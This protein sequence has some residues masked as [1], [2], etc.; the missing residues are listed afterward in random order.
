[1]KR[2]AP[3]LA[4]VM[5]FVILWN[6]IFFVVAHIRTVAVLEYALNLAGENTIFTWENDSHKWW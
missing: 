4:S 2:T 6:A 5:G 1:M 3:E